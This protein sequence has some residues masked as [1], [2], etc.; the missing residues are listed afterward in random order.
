MEAY[1]KDVSEAYFLNEIYAP[2]ELSFADVMNWLST[3]VPMNTAALRQIPHLDVC[4]ACKEPLAAGSISSM[5]CRNGHVW[6][7]CSVS[8]KCIN[9][10]RLLEKCTTCE[11]LHRGDDD[12]HS[13]IFCGNE[14]SITFQ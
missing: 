2:S 4:V 8:F 7:R 13:C 12:T 9:K 10:V 6:D 11:A 5:I 14:F 3:P 1:I